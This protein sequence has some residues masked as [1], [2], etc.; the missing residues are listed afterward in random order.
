MTILYN[1][2]NN[3]K[4]KKGRATMRARMLS[5]IIVFVSFSTMV[6]AFNNEI[7]APS[8]LY[9]VDDLSRSIEMYHTARGV[10][11][12]TSAW[13]YIIYTNVYYRN[14]AKSCW[15]VFDLNTDANDAGA[16][17]NSVIFSDKSGSNSVTFNLNA[18]ADRESLFTDSDATIHLRKLKTIV[19]RQYRLSDNEIDSLIK[20]IE[21]NKFAVNVR[22]VSRNNNYYPL[23]KKDFNKNQAKA[24]CDLLKFYKDIKNK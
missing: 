23:S 18:A 9:K 8:N 15:L 1:I 17:F 2:N 7:K 6:F 22:Y 16:N 24:L 14:N 20:L 10:D 11:T 21:D 3:L 13:G 19:R 4:L 12:L 5:F